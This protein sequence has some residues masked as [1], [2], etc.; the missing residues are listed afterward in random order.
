MATHLILSILLAFWVGSAHAGIPHDVQAIMGD[1]WL[2]AASSLANAT[3]QPWPNVADL[4]TASADDLDFYAVTVPPGRVH[5]TPT[6]TLVRWT[7]TVSGIVPERIGTAIYPP[8][9]IA[10]PKTILLFGIALLGLVVIG[11]IMYRVTIARR[12]RKSGGTSAGA[13]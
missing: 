6:G 5:M 2:S 9:A 11:P 10:A 13:A 1:D 7:E 8:A 3:D 4:L 12:R